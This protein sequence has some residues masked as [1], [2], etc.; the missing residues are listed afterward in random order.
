MAL[1]SLVPA[2]PVTTTTPEPQMGALVVLPL[3]AFVESGLP[4]QVKRKPGRPRKVFHGL[5]VDERDY[6]E[7]ARQEYLRQ[8]ATDPLRAAIAQ[9]HEPEQL[10]THLMGEV[11]DEAAQ[12]R[13]LRQESAERGST[14]AALRASGRHVRALMVLA[15]MLASVTELQAAQPPADALDR[16]WCQWRLLVSEAAVASLP[17]ADAEALLARLSEER[18]QAL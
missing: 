1:P 4:V 17:P 14:D 18:P 9:P 16:L 10:L 12:I 6:R 13:F 7:H 3:H 15:Q 2:A 8:L 5:T 11:A